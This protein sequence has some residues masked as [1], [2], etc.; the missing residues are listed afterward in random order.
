LALPD[1]PA[2]ADTLG[3][4]YFKRGLYMNALPLF[5]EAAKKAP[6]SVTYRVHLAATLYET[7]KKEQAKAELTP[8]LKKDA[9]VRKRPEVQKMIG[10][11]AL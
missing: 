6:D 4:V 2:V 9:S 3:W 7:G 5:Q 10:E 1:V 8:V 11:M